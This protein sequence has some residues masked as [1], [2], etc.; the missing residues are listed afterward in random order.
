MIH[1]AEVNGKKHPFKIGMREH[2]LLY[3][4]AISFNADID[5]VN[6]MSSKEAQD[7]VSID[8]NEV[9]RKVTTDFDTFLEMFHLASKKGCRLH[10]KETDEDIEPLTPEQIEDA[11][12]EDPQLYVKLQDI[13]VASNSTGKPSKKKPKKP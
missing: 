4:N 5:K 8:F 6:G 9:L 7:S 3:R 10:K 1:Y 11:V 13:F 2:Q 12:D